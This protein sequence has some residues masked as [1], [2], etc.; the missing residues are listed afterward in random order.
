MLLELWI[1]LG[2]LIAA[3]IGGAVVRARRKREREAASSEGSV[4][5]LW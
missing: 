4:Y 5:P 3:A 1:L 2:V